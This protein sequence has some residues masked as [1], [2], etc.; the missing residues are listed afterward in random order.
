MVCPRYGGH[1][2]TTTVIGRQDTAETVVEPGPRTAAEAAALRATLA[3]IVQLMLEVIGGRRPATPA[4]PSLASP[5]RN[6][7]SPP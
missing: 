5:T 1:L 6:A 2:Y 3:R 7:T 4:R